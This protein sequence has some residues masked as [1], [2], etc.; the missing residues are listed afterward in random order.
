MMR[1]EFE[2]LV[3]QEVTDNEWATVHAVYQ[4]Y[5]TIK[6]V[7]GKGQVA[8]LFKAHG[9]LIFHD[10]LP[11]TLRLARLDSKRIQLLREVELLDRDIKAEAEVPEVPDC[12]NTFNQ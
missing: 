1:Q 7:G 9:M 8:Q 4:W 3:G 5:P 12:D 11:R 2:K 6:D 10:M